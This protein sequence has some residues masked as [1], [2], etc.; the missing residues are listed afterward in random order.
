MRVLLLRLEIQCCCIGRQEASTAKTAWGLQNLAPKSQTLI[1]WSADPDTIVFPSGEKATDMTQL[2]CALLFSL[3]NS[4]VAAR[5]GTRG[6]MRPN[7]GNLGPKNAPESKALIVRSKD[8]D[9]IVFPSGEKAT[10]VISRLCAL[11][12]SL[13]SSSVSAWEGGARQI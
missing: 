3:F 10:E 4:S 8:P 11:L 2:L 5:E 6:Q 1:V 9:T 13:F 7:R 12:F